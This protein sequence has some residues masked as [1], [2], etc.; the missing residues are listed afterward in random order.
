MLNK[1]INLI[2][3][4]INVL[5]VETSDVMADCC[6]DRLEISA[7]EQT[8]Y[9]VTDTIRVTRVS[10]VLTALALDI[11]TSVL[12]VDELDTTLDPELM[13]LET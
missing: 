4:V 6:S 12:E 3:A 11:E 5:I 10:S 2:I 9:T 7:V 13:T 1:C 8:G